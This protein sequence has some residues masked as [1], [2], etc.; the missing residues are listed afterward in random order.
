MLLH[1]SHGVTLRVD[2]NVST[3]ITASFHQARRSIDCRS[4]YVVCWFVALGA[5]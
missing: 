5:F 3:A 1:L 2:P 4:L